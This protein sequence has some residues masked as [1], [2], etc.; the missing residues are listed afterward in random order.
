MP[1]ALSSAIAKKV[2]RWNQKLSK[3]LKRLTENNL[4]DSYVLKTM[5]SVS[6]FPSLA[7]AFCL[8][9]YSFYF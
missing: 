7:L 1:I 9:G 4:L 3:H 6:P 5:F 8:V 2:K